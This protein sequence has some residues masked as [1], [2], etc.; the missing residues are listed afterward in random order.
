MRIQIRVFGVPRAKGS[1]RAFY[2][3]RT[4]RAFVVDASSKS[5][6]WE[7][8]VRKAAV[9]AYNGPL[10]TG[11]L[12][13]D[14]RFILPRPKSHFGTGRNAH[15]RKASAPLRHMKKPDLDKLVRAVRDGLRQVVYRDDA[16]IDE[17]WADKVY[18]DTETVGCIIEVL[19][20]DLSDG[21]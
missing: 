19:A 4:Q 21:D 10:L 14:T 5:R 12:R 11:A 9:E 13:V 16:Q 17:G 20:E 2:N 15:R 8:A 1:K 18:N 6:D 7:E 3:K